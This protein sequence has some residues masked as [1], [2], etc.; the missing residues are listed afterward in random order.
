MDTG[1]HSILLLYAVATLSGMAAG[2]VVS[3]TVPWA[4]IIPFLTCL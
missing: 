4:D 3:A 2:Y 1:T